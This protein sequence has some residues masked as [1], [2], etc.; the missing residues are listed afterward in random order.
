MLPTLNF[1]RSAFLY[2][3]P[4]AVEAPTSFTS[5]TQRIHLI[6]EEFI[7]FHKVFQLDLVEFLEDVTTP[8]WWGRSR[9]TRQSLHQQSLHLPLL[10]RNYTSCYVHDAFLYSTYILKI[11]QT[12]NVIIPAASSMVEIEKPATFVALHWYSPNWNWEMFVIFNIPVGFAEGT[13]AHHVCLQIDECDAISYISQI[14]LEC[15]HS[16][17]EQASWS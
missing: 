6:V 4:S 7:L 13:R 16:V 14:H 5:H 2:I 9:V 11:K 17:P 15:T 12:K 8:G 3:C 10:L 1:S